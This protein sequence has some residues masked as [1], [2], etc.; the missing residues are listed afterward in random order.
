MRT[1]FCLR[2]C[3]NAIHFDR[4]YSLRNRFYKIFFSTLEL[5]NSL[6]RLKK[7]KKKNRPWNII[8]I[9]FDKSR[10]RNCIFL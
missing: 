4:L 5:L 1:E 7:Q 2:N 10:D 3:Q 8:I 9:Y 6:V